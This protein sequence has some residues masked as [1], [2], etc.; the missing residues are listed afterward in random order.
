MNLRPLILPLWLLALLGGCGGGRPA[1]PKPPPPSW[2]VSPNG[3]PLPFR[4]GQDDC[5]AALGAWFA[6]ADR[7]G[8]GVLD[9]AEMQ[10]DAARWFAL[11]DLDHDGQ[12][13]SDELETVRRRLLPQAEIPTDPESALRRRQ[14]LYSTARLDPVMQADANADFR[15]SAQEFRAYVDARFAELGRRGVVAPAQ[16]LDGCDKALP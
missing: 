5:R 9:R 1:E 11:A 4:A 13:T 12:L 16:V 10:A 15:V 14:V 2:T 8:D 6:T 7:N 3:E